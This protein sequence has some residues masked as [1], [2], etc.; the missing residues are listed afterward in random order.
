MLGSGAMSLSIEL[1][2][3]VVRALVCR[4]RELGLLAEPTPKLLTQE[5]LAEHYGVPVRSVRTWREKGLPGHK[6][7]KRVLYD[8]AEVDEWRAR[9]MR[10]RFQAEEIRRREEEELWQRREAAQMEAAQPDYPVY[11]A[12]P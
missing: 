1:S 8:V 12:Y 10:L 2:D 9:S 4:A 7:G 5:A 3:D 11:A 6:V